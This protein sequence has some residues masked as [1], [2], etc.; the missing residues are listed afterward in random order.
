MLRLH[1][2]TF[3][4]ATH[5]HK[6]LLT[7]LHNEYIPMNY[8]EALTIPHWKQAMIEELKALETNH[9]WDII[10]LP[11]LKRS[12]DC[13]WVF[14]I[15]YLSDGRIER[16]KASLVAQGYNQIYGIDYGETFAL[17]AKMNTIRILIALAV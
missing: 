13:K 5:Q 12:I 14:T 16:Y 7:S 4:K 6:A 11:P 15:K 9:T 3:S 1:V 10:H 17:V 8:N 2:I